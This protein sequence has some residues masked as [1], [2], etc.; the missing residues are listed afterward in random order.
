MSLLDVYVF[1]ENCFLLPSFVQ[2]S[3]ADMLLATVISGFRRDVDE[4]CVFWDVTQRRVVILYRYFRTTYRPHL[5]ES[6]SLLGLLY[7]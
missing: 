4:I 3:P 6:R 5:Q 2:E 7:P 1:N